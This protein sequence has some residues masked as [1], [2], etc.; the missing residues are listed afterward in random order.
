MALVAASRHRYYGWG[1]VV[2]F[3]AC[4]AARIGEVSGCL[5]GA[6][7]I[8]QWNW[9]V[10]RQTTPAPG[11]PTCTAPSAHLSALRAPRSLPSPIAIAIAR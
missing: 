8:G 3:A 7:G 1:E 6:I 4:T 2:L 11:G 9:T 10:R 5:V